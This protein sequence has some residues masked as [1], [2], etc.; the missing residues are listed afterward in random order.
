ML[1]ACTEQHANVVQV[2]IEFKANLNFGN[3]LH[4]DWNPL[5]TAVLSD[6]PDI[7]DL[8]LK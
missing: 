1:Y 3:K 2:L 6:C 5:H 7:V 4:W 8:L